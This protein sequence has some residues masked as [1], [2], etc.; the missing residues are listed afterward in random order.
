MD[1]TPIFGVSQH[2]KDL[3]VLNSITKFFNVGNLV[4]GGNTEKSTPRVRIPGTNNLKDN[5]IKH[6]TNYPLQSFKVVN[7]TIW[8]DSQHYL[9]KPRL[10]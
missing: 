5:V 3:H 7:Y 6:F 1:F 8:L 4:S 10:V 2:K 9:F